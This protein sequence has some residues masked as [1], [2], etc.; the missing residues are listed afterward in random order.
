MSSLNASFWNWFLF[1]VLVAC[2]FG[3]SPSAPQQEEDSR[4]KPLTILYGKYLGQHQ[5]TPPANEAELRKFIESQGP[6]FWANWKNV[7]ATNIFTSERDGQP[8]VILY[9]PVSGP[10]GP[11]GKPVIAYESKGMNGK[12][13]IG[14]DLGAVDE[15]DE[16][17]LRELVPNASAP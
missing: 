2:C 8:Y 16:A 12:R 17:R 4:L 13:Y 5:G 14:T 10:P 9:G 15:V 3:C 6:E 7:D 11:A 1:S